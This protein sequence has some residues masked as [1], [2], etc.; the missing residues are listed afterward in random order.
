MV[1]DT[2][3]AVAVIVG[4]PAGSFLAAAL[5]RATARLMSTASR[6]ELGIV[7]EARYGAVGADLTARFLRD[8]DITHRPLDPDCAER[9]IGA[10]RRCGKGRH[11][12]GLSYGDCSGY[13]LAEQTGLPLLCTGDDFAATDLE[14]LR[15]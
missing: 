3:A 7:L 2:W 6:V 13:A 5:E 15:P 12:A 10:W 8:A 11:V 14:V 4:E 1:V 9:A